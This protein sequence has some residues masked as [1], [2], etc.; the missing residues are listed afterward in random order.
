MVYEIKI[1][2]YLYNK[3]FTKN[4]NI[5]YLDLRLSNESI[6]SITKPIIAKKICKIIYKL[7]KTKK[8][9]ITDAFSNVGGATILF[10]QYFNFVNSFEINKLHCDMLLNNLNI[11]NYKDKVKI[12]CKD[13]L[14]MATKIKQDIIFF[15]PPWN[16]VNYKNEKKLSLQINNINICNIINKLLNYAKYLLLFA[17]FNYNKDDLQL[18]KAPYKIV[19]LN[20]KNKLF[21]LIIVNGTN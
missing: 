4:D 18:I 15:D 3:L 21:Y 10:A 8:I 16:C 11:Y 5:N 6:Y 19:K 17:P 2:N 7:F 14:K 13:Y 1:T 9:I 20:D 12:Y